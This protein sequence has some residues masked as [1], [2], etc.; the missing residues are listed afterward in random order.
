ML[1]ATDQS[2]PFVG[3]LSNGTSGDIN[4]IN[5]PQK[6][7]E[8]KR[9]ARYEKMQEVAET[10][11]SRVHEAHQQLRFHDWVPLAT[12]TAELPLRVRKP[13]PEMLK[14]FLKVTSANDDSA[15][16][17]V[18]ERIY[19]DRIAK[20]K[21]AP[22]EI[23]V[24]LQAVRIGDLGIAAIPFETFAEIGLELKD[25]SPFDQ[26]FTIE[27][28][29]GSYGYLPTPRQHRLGGYETW[30]GTNFVEVEAS[31]KIKRKLLELLGDVESKPSQGQ[32]K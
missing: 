28:A 8:R 31:T 21:N 18:R 2:P 24:P 17:H 10:V 1:L 12:A 13:T 26:T 6:D 27:L 4:N 19:A 29:N 14:H 9:Y 22:D 5:F 32:G 16:G 11:A 23:R 15:R 3:M 20:L 7:S 30:L 25:R